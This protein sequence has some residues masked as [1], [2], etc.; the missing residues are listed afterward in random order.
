MKKTI[1][2]SV[3]LFLFN[4]LSI[5][6]QNLYSQLKVESKF[7]YSPSGKAGHDGYFSLAF[8]HINSRH[9]YT[10]NPEG[11]VVTSFVQ[12]YPGKEYHQEPLAIKETPDAFIYYFKGTHNKDRLEAFRLGKQGGKTSLGTFTLSKSRREKLLHT[13]EDRGE[14]YF[15]LM[16]KRENKLILL[17]AMDE[18]AVERKEFQLSDEVFDIMRKADFLQVHTGRENNFLELKQE[19]AYLLNAHTLVLTRELEKGRHGATAGSTAILTLNFEQ[20]SSSFKLLPALAA[21]RSLLAN[22]FILRDRLYKISGNKDILDL[23]V[24]HFPSLEKLNNFTYNKEQ[25]ISLMKAGLHYRKGDEIPTIIEKANTRKI[26]RKLQKGT[27]AIYAKPLN[28]NAVALRIGSFHERSGGGG[29]MMMPMG[30]GT[31]STPMGSVS[32]PI[33]F[34]IVYFGNGRSSTN[35]YYFDV[36]LNEQL[37]ITGHTPP[38]GLQEKEENAIEGLHDRRHEYIL[39]LPISFSRGLM[40]F[41]DEKESQLNFYLLGSYSSSRPDTEKTADSF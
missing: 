33:S 24:Y 26:L 15:L 3:V 21:E 7:L 10:F 17:K 35:E 25:E 1:I 9:F 28:N 11:G 41:H 6:A 16:N 31:I 40:M 23:R 18:K 20:G 14:L 38:P 12:T 32:A 34:S 36:L 30:G 39:S 5:P 8:Y 19:K 2:L 37:K 13:I 22:T 27:L 4:T 29:S